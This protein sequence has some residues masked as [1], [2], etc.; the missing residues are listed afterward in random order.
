[1]ASSIDVISSGGFVQLAARGFLGL[2]GVNLFVEL[3]VE[4]ILGII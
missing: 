2:N 1:M 4:G 3:R